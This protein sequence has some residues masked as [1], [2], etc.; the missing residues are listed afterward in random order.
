VLQ[1]FYKDNVVFVFALG[2][3][4]RLYARADDVGIV[5]VNGDDEIDSCVCGSN[6]LQTGDL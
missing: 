3:D 2:R 1:S 4:Y 5:I 6:I